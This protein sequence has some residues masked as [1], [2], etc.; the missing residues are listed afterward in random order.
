MFHT[1]PMELYSDF[2]F[3]QLRLNLVTCTV[4][5]V[6]QNGL[7]P[8]KFKITPPVKKSGPFGAFFGA[9][10]H[11]FTIVAT[12]PLPIGMPT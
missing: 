12:Y 4:L 5:F 11:C 7:L 9:K 3:N 2:V 10:S 6:S 1:P 8:Y